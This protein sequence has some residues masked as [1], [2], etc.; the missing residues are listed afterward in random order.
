MDGEIGPG[1][2][3]TFRGEEDAPRVQVA[4]AD[5][6]LPTSF[7]PITTT[8]RVGTNHVIDDF[9]ERYSLNMSVDPG[10]RVAVGARLV[11]GPGVVGPVDMDLG[12]IGEYGWRVDIAS[13]LPAPGD[14]YVFNV[15]YDDGSTCDV[16]A[17]VT[18]V[19][20]AVPAPLAPLGTSSVLPTFTW[21]AP[22]PPP[23]GS[24][25]YTIWVGAQQGMSSVDVWHGRIPSTLPLSVTFND[26]GT[27]TQATLTPGAT[28]YW[29]VQA[30]DANG[31]SATGGA[32]FTV[33]GA[34]DAG[35]D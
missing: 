28:Y 19:L 32:T 2:L 33:S 1:D 34:S 18:G 27:A 26:D 10:L 4:G 7:M 21:S 35:A 20:G 25:E 29:T 3:A 13:G 6:H 30:T 12:D 15:T 8:A 14:T 5:L 17:G 16:S 31:N 24:F 9:G 11:G 22:V 23:A